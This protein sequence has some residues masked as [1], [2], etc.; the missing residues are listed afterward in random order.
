M[1]PTLSHEPLYR[2]TQTHAR[3]FWKSAN[4]ISVREWS[5]LT[6]HAYVLLCIADDPR[7]RLRDIASALDITER[8]AHAI[9]SD[10]VENGYVVKK[11]DGRRN[12]YHIEHRLP[13]RSPGG[14]EHTL[15]ELLA[16]LTVPGKKRPTHRPV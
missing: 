16:V 8:T 14:R 11:R 1:V 12:R 5:L 4:I 2:S 10:L 15:G 13:L 3:N 6:K 7:A 9:V